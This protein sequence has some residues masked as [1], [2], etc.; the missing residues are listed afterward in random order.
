MTGQ[1]QP[2]VLIYGYPLSSGLFRDQMQ[3]LSNRFEVITVDLRGI[4]SE[5]GVQRS[6]FYLDL[7]QRR[8]GA[9]GLS[10]H[11][12]TH[13]RPAFRGQHHHFVDV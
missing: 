7:C 5:H 3:A 4:R 9:D 8:N 13:D 12:P 1:G 10:W 11:G 6:G 2:V